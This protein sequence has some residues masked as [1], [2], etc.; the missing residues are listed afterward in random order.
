MALGTTA[1]TDPPCCRTE[2]E[3][4]PIIPLVPPPYTRGRDC[5]ARACPRAIF[6]KRRIWLSESSGVE[7]HC[8]GKMERQTDML[9]RD[10]KRARCLHGH[11]SR[12][13]LRKWVC[14]QMRYHWYHFQ[15]GT[16]E[17]LLA[18]FSRVTVVRCKKSRFAR[19][20]LNVWHSGAG[21]RIQSQICMGSPHT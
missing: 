5:V 6:F 20:P 19:S 16:Q 10:G 2:S 17:T 15:K 21:C 1:M 7:Q 8:D 3:M 14:Y 18:V 9:P 13:L 12:R 11:R 4:M